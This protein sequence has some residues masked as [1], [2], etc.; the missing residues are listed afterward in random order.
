[1]NSSYLLLDDI[2]EKLETAF[3]EVRFRQPVNKGQA[4]DA[5]GFDYY[6]QP[7]VYIGHM[8]TKRS[9]PVPLGSLPITPGPQPITTN[10]NGTAAQADEDF[11]FCLVRPLEG[12]ITGEMPRAHKVTV[13]I[14]SGIFTA[15]PVIEAGYQD[16]LNLTDIVL[17]VLSETR[18]WADNHWVQTL[19]IKWVSGLPRAL[20]V[21]EAGLSEHPFYGAVVMGEFEA[22]ATVQLPPLEVDAHEPVSRP[23]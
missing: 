9:L 21:Y 13:G 15:E 23:Y 8:P 4:F 6:R 22:A 3:A 12:Q 10:G 2:R 18:F 11:P 1:M 16:I 17:R 20:S 14:I 7:V 19:P 5:G